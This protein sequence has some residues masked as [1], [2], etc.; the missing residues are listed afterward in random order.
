M[1]V[2]LVEHRDVNEAG[3]VSSFKSGVPVDGFV[4]RSPLADCSTITVE[5]DCRS[6]IN[7][8]CAVRCAR[9]LP[10]PTTLGKQ[11]GGLSGE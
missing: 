4:P 10:A 8:S 9:V 5:K 2:P 1:P 6:K 11:R 7:C 3:L